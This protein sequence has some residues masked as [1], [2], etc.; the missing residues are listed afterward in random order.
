MKLSTRIITAVLLVVGSSGVVYAFSKHGDWGMSSAEKVEF[1]SE[2]VS[3]KLGLD[4]LQRQNFDQLAQTVVE[5]M[6]EVKPSREQHINEISE[7]LQEPGFDQ[8]RALQMV[9]Q[10]T[11][12]IDE[13]A[14]QVIAS[15]GIFLDSLS[16]EQRQQLQELMKHRHG[17]HGRHLSDD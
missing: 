3:K 1:V 6:Q 15:L 5:I 10:K 16:A 4:E 14:P 17:Q 11:R 12:L 9:Q 2:R 8:A 13:K 7:L